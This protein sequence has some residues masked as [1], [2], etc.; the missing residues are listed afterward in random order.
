MLFLII[1][2]FLSNHL[3]IV[4]DTRETDNEIMDGNI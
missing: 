1:N 2:N 3:E 4:L